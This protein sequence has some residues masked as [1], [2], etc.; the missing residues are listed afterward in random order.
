MYCNNCGKEYEGGF[1][2]E[3]GT[4][5]QKIE[6]KTDSKEKRFSALENNDN[7]PQ[8][9]KLSAGPLTLCGERRLVTEFQVRGEQITAIFYNKTTLNKP[10][11]SSTFY[12]KNIKSV[13]YNTRFYFETIYKINFVA[14]CFLIFLGVYLPYLF[15]A[16]PLAVFIICRRSLYETMI[17]TLDSGVQIKAYYTKRVETTEIYRILTSEGN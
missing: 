3:C 10:V 6:L 2:P 14:F 4:S 12:K 7:E 15:I 1:C 9:F 11:S 17:V 16:I 5:S 13:I 8:I